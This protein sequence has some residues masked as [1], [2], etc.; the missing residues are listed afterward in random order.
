MTETS[1]CIS[2]AASTCAL[3][4]LIIASAARGPVETLKSVKPLMVFGATD[5]IFNKL[6]ARIT[7]ILLKPG[8]L[9]E[10]IL[11]LHVDAG[12]VL[13]HQLKPMLFAN[14]ALDIAGTNRSTVSGAA[15][16]AADSLCTNG[17]VHVIDVIRLQ[18]L[19]PAA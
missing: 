7:E 5:G 12:Q 13:G 8:N 3:S 18:A 4:M 10:E 9:A 16:V 17:V 2:H 19:I 1:H 14:K 15:V 11:T 6:P